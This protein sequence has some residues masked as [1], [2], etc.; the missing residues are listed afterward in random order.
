MLPAVIMCAQLRDDFLDGWKNYFDDDCL[1]SYCMLM[2]HT[3]CGECHYCSVLYLE[4]EGS[5]VKLMT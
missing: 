3:F 1:G 5:D 4:S 2:R